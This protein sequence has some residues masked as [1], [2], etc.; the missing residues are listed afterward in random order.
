M[1]FL[2]KLEASIAKNNSLLCIGLDTDRKKIPKHLNGDVFAFNKAVIDAT[3]DI[4]S[5][6]KLNSA[7]YEAGGTDGIEM[8]KK[9]IQYIQHQYT[10][11]SVILDAKRADIGLTSEQYAKAVFDYINTDAVTI[12]PYLGLDSVEPFLKREEKG[13][14]LLCRTSNPGAKDFQDLQVYSSSDPPAPYRSGT[15][16]AGGESRR[17]IP[18]YMK[19]AEKIIEWGK[20]YKNC[21]MVIGA[22]YP[23]EMKRI[24]ELTPDMFFLVPGIGAQGGDL[25]KTLQAGLRNDKSGLIIHSSRTIIYASTDTDFA[26]KAREKAIE[27]RDAI[28]LFR[29]P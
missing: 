8:L 27:I 21:L 10:S 9:T 5:S 24:R 12:N 1:N 7:Y 6:Y 23:N 17:T 20:K 19:V 11:I 22:T 2:Q 28:N 25:E 29:N 16:P 4:V 15:G 26:E 13:I 18:L 3:Y 14:I